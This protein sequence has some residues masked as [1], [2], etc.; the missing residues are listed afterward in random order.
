LDKVINWVMHTYVNIRKFR[1][2]DLADVQ[3]VM[4]R[5]LSPSS[6]VDLYRAIYL[7]DKILIRIKWFLTEYSLDSIFTKRYDTQ[8]FVAEASKK[9]VGV[10]IIRYAGQ[11]VWELRRLAVHP[12]NRGKGIGSQ[13]IS[14]IMYYVKQRNGKVITLFTNINNKRAINLHRRFGFTET[15][16]VMDLRL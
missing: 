13:L 9:V 12:N 5:A 15:R 14:K 8:V 11:D 4:E 2:Q 7:Y 16:T 3:M 10:A 6:L 1:K